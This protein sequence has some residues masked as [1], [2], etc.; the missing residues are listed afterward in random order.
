M[1]RDP[2]M[3]DGRRVCMVLDFLGIVGPASSGH[4]LLA[5]QMVLISSPFVINAGP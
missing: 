4:S 2:R 5:G 3:G 1:H